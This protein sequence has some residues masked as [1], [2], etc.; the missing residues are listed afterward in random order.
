MKKNLWFFCMV[1]ISV[2]MA[3][4]EKIDLRTSVRIHGMVLGGLLLPMYFRDS[5]LHPLSGEDLDKACT[6]L[7]TLIAVDDPASR[8]RWNE[9]IDWCVF[10]YE[11]R[12]E[13]FGQISARSE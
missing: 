5:D 11:N 8:N 10:G 7:S 3:A 13:K 9:M 4:E 1:L 6:S 2:S 12:H